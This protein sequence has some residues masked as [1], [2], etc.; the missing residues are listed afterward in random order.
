MIDIK[1][2]LLKFIGLIAIIF[3]VM[4]FIGLSVY[5]WPFT[6]AAIIA[7]SIKP[8]IE[9][10]NKKIK[11]PRKISAFIVVALVYV[12][13]GFI[14][15]LM[16]TKIIK[17]SIV[18]I[19]LI[20]S[21]YE[22][23][24][25]LFRTTFSKFKEMNNV[26]PDVVSTKIYDI[27]MEVLATLSHVI[28]NVLNSIFDF[29]LFLP[30]LVIYAV[31]TILATYFFAI[32]KN[33]IYNFLNETLPKKWVENFVNI[34]KKSISS[35]FNY[36][37]AELILVG[38][39]FI[40]L[41][42]SFLIIKEPYPF[43]ISIVL[44][45][46][47]LLP[48]VGIGTVMVPWIIYSGIIGNMEHAIALTIIYGLVLVIRQLIEPKII[49]NSIG[50]KPIITLITMYIGFKTFGVIGM[51]LGP[52]ITIILK[53]VLTLVLETG[54]LKSMFKEKKIKKIRYYKEYNE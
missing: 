50:I 37:K 18:L 21:M 25:T 5:F 20:P 39:S 48:V 34:V 6:L 49:S 42:I 26:L 53:D 9:Y 23:A 27:G 47:D 31:V 28:I 29:I 4:C 41:V 8:V 51:I 24:E 11:V 45:I 7:F 44:A 2:F 3:T 40:E 43:T 36:L 14:L 1:N 17:E 32:D 15:F 35:L 22:K 13:I 12:I 10:I 16:C 46:L 30:T 52:I 38:I 54:Y 33:M 19:D